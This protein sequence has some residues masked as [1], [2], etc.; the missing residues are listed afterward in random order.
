MF[1]T[2]DTF[3]SKIIRIQGNPNK[4]IS[5]KFFL[6][7]NA[8][9]S[10]GKTTSADDLA[11]GIET[12]PSWDDTS[13]IGTSQLEITVHPNRHAHKPGSQCPTRT[14]SCNQLAHLHL[15]ELKQ[16]KK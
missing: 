13:E 7:W 2:C 11:T 10:S 1:D 6:T 4:S 15:N 16:L 9:P 8:M 14:Q 3:F 12:T 5:L